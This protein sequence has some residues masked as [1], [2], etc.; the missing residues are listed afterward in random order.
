MTTTTKKHRDFVSEPIKQK[1]V[2]ELPG[3]GKV[4]G[5]RLEEKGFNKA[6]KLMGQFLILGEDKKEFMDWLRSKCGANPKQGGDCYNALNNW[7]D[8]NL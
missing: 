7:C 8:N 3:I 2:T 4:L 6:R 1:H 5:E